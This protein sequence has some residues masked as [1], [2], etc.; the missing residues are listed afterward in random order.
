MKRAWK[1]GRRILIGAATATAIAL[2]AWVTV[3][4]GIVRRIAT[5]ELQRMGLGNVALQVRGVSLSHVQMANVAAGEGERLRV[6]AVGVG[7]TLGGLLGGRLRVIELTGLETEIRLR[8]GKLDLGP[9]AEMGGGGEGENPFTQIQLRSSAILLDLE[10][11]RLRIPVEGTIADTGG[12][13]L[14]LDLQAGGENCTARVSGALDTN[15]Y[16]LDFFQVEAQ[17]REVA[18]LLAILT[19]RIANPPVRVHGPVNIRTRGQ[20]SKG[21][22]DFTVEARSGR[23]NASGELG[24][25]RFSTER[26]DFDIGVHLVGSKVTHLHSVVNAYDLA[27]DALKLDFVGCA[28]SSNPDKSMSFKVGYDFRGGW[29]KVEQSRVTGV[30]EALSGQSGAVLADISLWSCSLDPWVL[31]SGTP[32]LSHWVQAPSAQRVSVAGRASLGLTPKT[33]PAGTDWTWKLTVPETLVT[34]P[35][36]PVAFPPAGVEFSSLRAQVRVAAEAGPDGLRLR[37]PPYSGV[38]AGPIGSGEGSVKLATAR[39]QAHVLELGVTEEATLSAAVKDGKLDWTVHAPSLLFRVQEGSAELPGGWTMEGLNARAELSLEATPSRVAVTLSKRAIIGVRAAK[40]PALDLQRTSRGP[41]L[42]MELGAGAAV[43]VSL[44]G[45]KPDWSL[46][47]PELVAW[48]GET[49]LMLPNALGKVEG[50]RAAFTLSGK[51]GPNEARLESLK[52]GKASLKSAQL[53]VGGQPLR[54]GPVEF[55]A[56]V[57][58]TVLPTTLGVSL[59]TT[60]EHAPATASVAG[61]DMTAGN[62]EV[63][64]RVT[65]GGGAP[66]VEGKVAL[67]KVA[68]TH[69]ASGLVVA[70]LSAEVPVSW[71]SEKPAEGKFTVEAIEAGGVKLANVSGTLGVADMRAEFT[72]AAEPLKGAKLGVEGSLDASRGAPQGSARLSLPLFSLDDEEALGRL[73][74]ALKGLAASGTFGVDGFARLAGGQVRP[75]LTLTVLDGAFKSKAWEAD[76]EGVFATVRLSSLTPPLTPRKELQIALVKRAKMGEL[77]VKD[78]S[79]AFRLEPVEAE[80]KPLRWRVFVQ[81]AEAG[82]AGGRLYAEAVEW[83]PLAPEHTVTVHA[84]DLKLGDLLAMVPEKRATGV[85]AVS[86]VLPVTIGQWPDLRFGDGRLQSAKDQRGWLQIR[87]VE[88]LKP[89]IEAIVRSSVPP[90]LK[91]DQKAQAEDQLRERFT[92]ALKEFEYDELRADLTNRKE[93]FVAS[94]TLRGRGRFPDRFGLRQEFAGLVF[95]FPHLDKAL[96]AAILEERDIVKALPR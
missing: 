65:L 96:K 33:T 41:L 55:A 64:G 42:G 60:P 53:I 45:E 11:Q 82:W 1:W 79:L 89:G 18:G 66:V 95:N 46:D 87:D 15:T 67:D 7:F 19:T 93:G 52:P 71:N 94:V 62:A 59:C 84:D 2:A 88:P 43:S 12:G 69:K 5:A 40:V 10:G 90:H 73:V 74:P 72:V 50:L 27:V 75:T 37:V 21:V 4:P 80:G 20:R 61:T 58:G 92:S 36:S 17:V 63:S 77:E 81:R 83:D 70:G 26:F 29:L 38:A 47:V 54:V 24:G 16:D 49:D 28:A 13:K 31:L 39:G 68:V 57:A 76:A 34:I 9:L 22:W 51:A 3:V 35:P 32:A 44:G 48:L 25:H 85:G 6:G 86:G 91:G 23:M 30:M 14:Q 78:G 56:T 8:D